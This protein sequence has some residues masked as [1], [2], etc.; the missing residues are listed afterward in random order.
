MIELCLDLDQVVINNSYKLMRSG[1]FVKYQ[2]QINITF[3]NLIPLQD[4]VGISHYSV[5]IGLIN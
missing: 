3:V 4:F 1:K 2:S 5:I